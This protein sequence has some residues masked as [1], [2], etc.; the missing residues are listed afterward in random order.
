MLLMGALLVGVQDIKSQFYTIMETNMRYI[1]AELI[2]AIECKHLYILNLLVILVI[3]V[4]SESIYRMV[5]DDQRLMQGFWVYLLYMLLQ[6]QRTILFF[7]MI[8]GAVYASS[9]TEDVECGFFYSCF[10]RERR[11]DYIKGKIVAN[12][13]AIN[14]PFLV[15]CLLCG[16]KQYLLLH[17]EETLISMIEI[18]DSL[19]MIISTI[20]KYLMFNF[21]WGSFAMLISF[22]M[23][24]I[25]LAYLSPFI[26][27]YFLVIIN[28]QFFKELKIL[29]P[30]FW[31]QNDKDWYAGKYGQWFFLFLL[32]VTVNMILIV[33]VLKRY[34]ND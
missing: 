32:C 34:N 16:V 25:Y 2:R 3:F 5:E 7:A 23:K 20:I 19:S 4:Q 26:G 6:N 9:L 8:S 1:W 17:P 29:N 31:I 11:I 15:S 22:T 12:F 10:C 27:F 28:Q 24:S 33:T 21:F 30:Y 18:G 14:L 13:C